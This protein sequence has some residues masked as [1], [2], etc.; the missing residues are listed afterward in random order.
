MNIQKILMLSCATGALVGMGGAA[1][2]QEQDS[3]GIGEVVVTAEKRSQS[4]QEVPVAVTAITSEQRDIL[5][6]T[7]AQ[8]ITNFTPGMN[9]TNG[10]RVSLRGAGKFNFFLG[11]DPGVASYSDGF[12]SYSFSELQKRPIFVSRT[13]ILRGPQGTLYGRNSMGGAINTI[14]QRPT[15]EWQGELRGGVGN[16]DSRVLEGYVSGPIFDNLRIRAAASVNQRGEGYIENIG[17][18]EDLAD[19]DKTYQE[20]QLEWDVNSRMTAW[21]RYSRSTW[22]DNYGVGNTAVNSDVPYAVNSY[23]GYY[24]EQYN[25][26]NGAGAQFGS[27]INAPDPTA[28]FIPGQDECSVGA[29]G[30]GTFVENPGVR[31]LYTISTDQPNT[32]HLHATELAIAHLDY[33]LGD[34]IHLKYITGYQTYF[35]DSDADT[36]YTSRDDSYTQYNFS[37]YA[38]GACAANQPTN[39][40]INP[41]GTLGPFGIP[42]PTNF[43]GSNLASNLTSAFGSPLV[44]FGFAPVPIVCGEATQFNPATRTDGSQAGFYYSNEI[45]ISNS[46]DA[47]F[48]WLLGVFQYHENTIQR[49]TSS[50]LN[51]ANLEAANA[52]VNANAALRQSIYGFRS[53]LEGTE[54]ARND[55]NNTGNTYAVYAQSDWKLDDTWT[56]TTGLRYTHDEKSVFTD[57]ALSLYNPIYLLPGSPTYSGYWLGGLGLTTLPVV[58][59][60]MYLANYSSFHGEGS[61]NGVTGTINLQWQPDDETMLY[62]RYS[63]GYKGVGFTT[64]TS[65]P[66]ATFEPEFVNAYEVGFKK[67]F[68]PTLRTNVSMFFNQYDGLQLYLATLNATGQATSLSH[69]VDAE[70]YGAELELTW[71]PIEDFTVLF[72]YGY[73]STEITDD[74]S[75]TIAGFRDPGFYDPADPQAQSPGAQRS[76][77][78]LVSDGS[79]I[80]PAVLYRYQR[81]EGN[82]LPQAPENKFALNGAYTFHTDVGNFIFSSTYAYTSELTQAAFASPVYETDSVGITDFRLVFQEPDGNFTAIAYVKNAFEEEGTNSN[83]LLNPGARYVPGTGH[84]ASY[85]DIVRERTPLDPRFFGVELQYR[86]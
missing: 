15:D 36:G 69:N 37:P 28:G 62:G 50:L 27:S 7:T 4:I 83:G 18:Y 23:S 32:G 58:N 2:A 61:S 44:S 67:D 8:D 43:A 33:D 74:K 66:D 81:L 72:T 19:M 39:P 5:G 60:V 9:R 20:L 79:G 49:I 22:D 63:R 80:S 3:T 71:Q 77:F 54:Y 85:N 64:A 65:T 42:V 75:P 31:D 52:T 10:D 78:E 26:C 34:D 41:A 12:Y 45:N 56:L 51:D 6:I 13:E 86:F 55:G 1:I 21:V 48:H 40:D 47:D 68:G 70:S 14:S 59:G 29:G 30:D 17:H 53:P 38:G 84:Q 16:Y 35:Y 82:R 25:F 24:N 57:A 46:A 73:L 76:G 11:S